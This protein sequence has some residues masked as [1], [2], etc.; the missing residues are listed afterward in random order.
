MF[1]S[2]FGTRKGSRLMASSPEVPSL[3]K[4]GLAVDDR[5]QVSFVN[6]FSFANVQRF[7]T[8]ENFCTEVVRAFHGHLKEEKFVLAVAGSAIVAA[9]LFGDPNSP[10]LDSKP[11]R[12]VL[13][14]RQPQILHIPAGYANGFRPLESKTRLLFFSS[15]TLEESA[16]DDYRFP[17]D[18]W[19]K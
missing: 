5:G 8:V 11:H 12:F 16:K 1:T 13:S 10:K 6:G 15:A 19:G 3:V 14:D 9:V 18:H 17:Y 2:M 4:G 7:Y